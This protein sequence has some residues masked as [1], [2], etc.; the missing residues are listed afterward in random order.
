LSQAEALKAI[1]PLTKARPAVALLIL[2]GKQ[3]APKPLTFE[4]SKRWVESFAEDWR[5]RNAPAAEQS[6]AGAH[7]SSPSQFLWENAISAPYKI[8]E[9]QG[10]K[11]IIQEIEFAL[12]DLKEPADMLGILEEMARLRTSGTDAK[13]N[14]FERTRSFITQMSSYHD[15]NETWKGIQRYHE[16]VIDFMITAE[17]FGEKPSTESLLT[18]KTK[19]TTAFAPFL[20]A[21]EKMLLCA[22]FGREAFDKAFKT[23]EAFYSLNRFQLFKALKNGARQIPDVESELTREDEGILVRIPGIK[24]S[25]HHVITEGLFAKL[26]DQEKSRNAQP[27]A[28]SAQKSKPAQKAN[29]EPAK[30]QKRPAANNDREGY[31]KKPRVDRDEQAVLCTYCNKPNHTASEC[32]SNPASSQFKGTDRT[33]KSDGKNGG[34]KNGLGKD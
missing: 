19:L 25:R 13:Q 17:F 27:N 29:R 2:L 30:T 6:K 12:Q 22:V 1:G 34:K 33:G 3:L 7:Y 9:V 31:Y 16:S 8:E 23:D 18:A 14:D 10:A 11:N 28:E 21:Q 32:Y 20:V 5:R 26:K 15:P 24:D 4:N